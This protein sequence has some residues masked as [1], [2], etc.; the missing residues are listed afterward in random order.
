V[1]AIAGTV[2]T[3]NSPNYVGELFNVSPV[4]T[5]FLSAIGGLTGGQSVN[6]VMFT[7]ET[8]DLRTAD[9]TRQG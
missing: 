4:D 3:F 6:S 9:N 5:P 1:A 2:T 7:W 8:T